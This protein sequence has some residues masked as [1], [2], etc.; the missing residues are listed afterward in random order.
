MNAHRLNEYFD[1]DGN[2]HS[3]VCT[4]HLDSDAFREQCEK[5]F[6][7]RPRVVKHFWQ[8]SKWVKRDPE[9]KHSRG[10]ST[11]VSLPHFEY[12]AKPITIGLV[13]P[14]PISEGQ[15]TVEN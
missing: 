9:R 3:Y 15:I 14:S 1:T 7:V 4:G 11:H 6:A 2:L 12:G 8:K 10:F 5:Q 13:V